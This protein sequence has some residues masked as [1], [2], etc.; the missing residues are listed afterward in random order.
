MYEETL[1]KSSKTATITGYL[2][3]TIA[4]AY[5]NTV[6]FDY[7][8]TDTQPYTFTSTNTNLK[9]LF[10]RLHTW[11]AGLSSS[12]VSLPMLMVGLIL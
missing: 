4:D 6:T 9:T 2:L 7:N 1:N 11:L 10:N 8:R 3:K 5:V 12:T